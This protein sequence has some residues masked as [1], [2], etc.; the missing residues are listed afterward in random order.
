VP[1][2][3]GDRG[4]TTEWQSAQLGVGC[5]RADPV[6]MS[7]FYGWRVALIWRADFDEEAGPLIQAGH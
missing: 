3:T 6:L 1:V 5:G 4:C 7:S 2:M